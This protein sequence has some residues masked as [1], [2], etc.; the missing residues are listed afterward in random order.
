MGASISKKLIPRNLSKAID[1]FESTMTKDALDDIARKQ[2]YARKTGAKYTDPNAQEGGFKRDSWGEGKGEGMAQETRQ[3]DFLNEDS[4]GRGGSGAGGGNQEMP[5][6]LLNFLNAAGPAERKVDKSMTSTKVY[7][8]LLEEDGEE[9]QKKQQAGQRTR[10]TMLMVENQQNQA[11][12]QQL[13]Q[14]QQDGGGGEI[15]RGGGDDLLDMES[16]SVK[17]GLTTTRTTSFSTATAKEDSAELKL[18]DGELFQFLVSVGQKDLAPEEYLRRR[19]AIIEPDD[20]SGDNNN[21]NNNNKGSGGG[22]DNKLKTNK[23]NMGDTTPTLPRITEEEMKRNILY[24]QSMCKYNDIPVLLQDTDK[25]MIGAWKYNTEDLERQKIHPATNEARLVI[26][27][28]VEE[29][30]VL[31]GNSGGGGM[32]LSRS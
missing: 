23:N 28:E 30:A 24:L 8:S 12:L 22:G 4:G 26:D 25:T 16:D 31:V 14:Q 10:R 6:D 32:E 17:A 27:R 9:R 29:K 19:F 20:D 21:N 7:E 13:Q 18:T 5:Q 3:R 15:R 11:Q 1:S 2:S